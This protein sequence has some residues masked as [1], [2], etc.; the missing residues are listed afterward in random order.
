MFRRKFWLHKPP[1]EH[2]HKLPNLIVKELPD[3][4]P[5]ETVNYECPRI[6]SQYLRPRIL[7]LEAP[8]CV[9]LPKRGA[10]STPHFDQVKTYFNLFEPPSPKGPVTQL[11]YKIS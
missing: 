4:H 2:P 10:Y 9:V 11:S 1:T 5:T 7:P 3:F 6:L 8:D